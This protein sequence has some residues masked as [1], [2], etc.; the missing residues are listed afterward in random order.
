[1][2][3]EHISF[4]RTDSNK[5]I[6]LKLSFV[7]QMPLL[8]EYYNYNCYN[9]NLFSIPEIYQSGYRTCQ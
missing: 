3:Y 1:M 6:D 5:E 8:K 7:S 9:Y 2:E 4:L